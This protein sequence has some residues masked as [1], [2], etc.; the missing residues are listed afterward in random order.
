MNHSSKGDKDAHYS[1]E[2]WSETDL[3]NDV[4]ITEDPPARP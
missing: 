1:V 4:H 3:V 2:G